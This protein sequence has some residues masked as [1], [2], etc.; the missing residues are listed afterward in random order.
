MKIIFLMTLSFYV[1]YKVTAIFKVKA[2][3]VLNVSF[4]V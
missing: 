2:D 4:F 1:H 3:G